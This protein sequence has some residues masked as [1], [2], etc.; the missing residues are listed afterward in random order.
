MLIV[1]TGNG[2]GKTTSAIGQTIRALGQGKKVFFAQFIKSDGYPSG[3]DKM[4]RGLAPRVKFVKG[5][6]GFVGI[7]GDKL[8]RSV[9]IAAARK[10]LAAG[11]AAVKSGRYDLIIM[12]EA[13]VA[14]SL[15]L[16]T[17]KDLVALVRA[18]PKDKD[19]ILTGRGAHSQ[20]IKMASLVTECTEIKHPYYQKVA[21][22]KGL[23]Y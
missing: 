3:E 9:H 16:I 10:T 20:I 5:G 12:D 2:K 11:L 23:E 6:K 13:N 17:L 15:K 8:P 18:T 22:R 4:L 14:L 21:A 7:L 1:I 19:L